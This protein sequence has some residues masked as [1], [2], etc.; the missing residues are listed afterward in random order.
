M[1]SVGLHMAP[2]IDTRKTYLK[3]KNIEVRAQSIISILIPI[4]AQ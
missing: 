3:K 2:K 1:S 4:H